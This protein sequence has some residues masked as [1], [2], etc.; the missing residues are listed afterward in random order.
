MTESLFRSNI[1][2]LSSVSLWTLDVALSSG[3]AFIG[4]QPCGRAEGGWATLSPG[5]DKDSVTILA[6]RASQSKSILPIE[7]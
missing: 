6:T 3:V 5:L 4:T 2:T 7:N 1:L